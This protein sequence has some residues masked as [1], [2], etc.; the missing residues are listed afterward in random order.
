MS[1]GSPVHVSEDGERVHLENVWNLFY[2][3]YWL[4][5]DVGG[6]SLP[7]LNSLVCFLLNPWHMEVLGPVPGLGTKIPFLA[8]AHGGQ[9]QN[10]TKNTIV[11]EFLLHS[12]GNYI[13]SLMMEHDNVRKKNVYM[14]M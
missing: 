12:T 14:Y 8:T 10:K 6:E 13:Q 3:F 7:L 11:K 2:W 4:I 1:R 5:L 9:K